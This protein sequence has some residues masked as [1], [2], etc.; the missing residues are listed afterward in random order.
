MVI[1]VPD[2]ILKR[3]KPQK[4]HSVLRK[5]AIALR[6]NAYRMKAIFRLPE[7]LS[8]EM[9]RLVGA[10]FNANQKIYGERLPSKERQL[11]RSR[12]VNE[13]TA[14]HGELPPDFIGWHDAFNDE[15]RNPT[16]PT[17]GIYIPPNAEF[18]RLGPE[19]NYLLHYSFEAILSAIV[20][21][22]WML[23]ESLAVSAWVAVVNRCPVPLAV[24][25]AK[26]QI[27]FTA[28][29]DEAMEVGK[30]IS[31]IKLAEHKFVIADKMGTLLRLWKKVDFDL[32]GATRSAYRAAFGVQVDSQVFNRP[33]YTELHG[34]EALRNLYAHQGGVVDAKF[35]KRVKGIPELANAPE[36]EQ[37]PVDGEIVAKYV[38]MG[39]GCARALLAFV[40]EWINANRKHKHL[41][42]PR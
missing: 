9:G 17:A 18:F 6:L 20:V 42:K 13:Y 19:R 16:D 10:A 3:L 22:A 26:A 30:N 29:V 36:D 1:D 8:I 5:S 7:H 38:G 14:T 25:V 41:H 40:D 24:N 12:K 32:L 23:L 27:K 4:V 15:Y 21:N 35:L 39:L 2:K 11:E 34:L 28:G 37:F 33:E 31:L